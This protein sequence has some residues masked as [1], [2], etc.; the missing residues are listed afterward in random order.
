MNCYVHPSV[1]AVGT[2][3]NCGRGICGQCATLVGGKL[4]CKD[5]AAAGGPFLQAKKTNGLSIASMVTGIVSI[6][7]S[8]CYGAGLPFGIAALIMGIIARKQIKETAQ[9]GSGMAL[10]GIITGGIVT[11]LAILGIITIVI[12]LILGPVIGNVF[13]QI[14]SS[15][16]Y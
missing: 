5:C 9:E 12:L 14:N 13:T 1:N 8:F 10:T 3:Q 15:L 2:C 11:G 7:L 16:A 6:P 4:Y